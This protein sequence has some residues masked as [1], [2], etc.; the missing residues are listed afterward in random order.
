MQARDADLNRRCCS[1]ARAAAMTRHAAGGHTR[2]SCVSTT[3]STVDST[4]G[5]R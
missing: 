5:A 2:G 4:A 1:L 3:C